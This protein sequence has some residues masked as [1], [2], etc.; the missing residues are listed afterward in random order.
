MSDILRIVLIFIFVTNCSL[1]EK[2]KFWKNEKKIQISEIEEVDI[3]RNIEI[4][5]IKKKEKVFNS[6][7]NAETKIILSN[8]LITKSTENS[9]NNNTGRINY[10]GSL[11]KISK[12]KFSK[13]KNFLQYGPILLF[14]DENV[15]FFDSKGSIFKIGN[16][17]NLIWKKNYYSKAEKKQN[18][19]LTFAKNKQTLIVADNISKYYALN[20]NTGKILWE[21]K[22]SSPFNSQIKTFQDKF[23]VIDFENILRAYSIIDGKEIWSSRTDSTLVRSQKKL[24]MVIIGSYIYFNNSLGD[25]SAIDIKTGELMWQ[26]PTQSTS[27]YENVYALENSQ[28][29]SDNKNLYFSNNKNKFFSIDLKTGSINW[30]QTVNSSLKSTLIE[31]Y[32]FTISNNGFLIIMD[33]NSG[34]VIRITN[35]FEKQSSKF[36]RSKKPKDSIVPVGF[37]MGLK[38]IYLTTNKGKLYTIDILT[39]KTTKI[40]S[41]DSEKISRPFIQN[42]YLYVIKDN[43]IIKLD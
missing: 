22:N 35:L 14:D 1:G 32:I 13:I 16:D 34:N 9:T 40:L 23:F 24:S 12:F 29:I 4:D 37:I 2:S 6:E 39:G 19:V 43:S 5:K 28:V 30:Q 27:S 25:I 3:V 36:L 38:N 7:F 15:I 11:N 31:K 41:I 10:N 8:K 17:S 26:R 21:Q 42:Q 20:I 18:P 33:K